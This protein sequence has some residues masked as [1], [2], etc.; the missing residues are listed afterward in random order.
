MADSPRRNILLIMTDQQRWDTLGCYGAPTCRTPHIDGLAARGVRFDAAYTPTSPCSPARAA[1]FTGL[2]PHK[3]NVPMNGGILNQDVPN[4][5]TELSAAGYNLGYSGKWHVDRARVPSEYGFEGKDFPNYGYPPTHGLIEGLRYMQNIDMPPH[6]NEYLAERGLAAP[7]VLEA[8]YGDNPSRQ[9]QEMYALQSGGVESSF[10]YMVSDFAVALMNQFAADARAGKPFFIWANFW[11][12]H[13]PCLVPEPYY[14][15]Y[16]PEQIPEEPSF[17]ETWVNKPGAHDLYERYWG[18]RSGGWR[19][20]REIVAR[21]WGYVTMIDDLVGRM[22]AALRALGLEEETLVVFTTDHGDQ[23]GA[24]RLIEKGPFAY[25]ESWH[26]PLIA[27]HPGCQ[28]P[29][30][31]CEAFVYLHDLFPTFLE[32]AGRTPPDVPDSASILDNILG[33]PAPTQ[34]DSVY[35]SF[36]GHILPAP[37]R[38]VRT[39]T[40]KLVFNRCDIGELYDLRHDPHELINL[41][42]QPEAQMV[43]DELL[44]KLRAC[45]VALEDP[46]LR[47]LDGLRYVY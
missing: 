23:M 37:L 39:R 30:S 14:S 34:R 46:M 38:F 17:T 28:A 22:L 21:Y 13:T 1:L 32:V 15:M 2:Y 5:T 6:Y 10:E 18:L 19:M 3:N 20:W 47:D 42:A 11:G 7:K 9:S 43:K 31:V 40:H 25:E 26:L 36:T 33:R 35:G 29:G 24:H 45:M 12:P 16:D 44:E 27:A 8:Y 4:L 41:I